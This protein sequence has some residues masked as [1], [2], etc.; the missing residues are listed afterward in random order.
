MLHIKKISSR[1]DTE[2]IADDIDRAIGGSDF[3]KDPDNIS[4]IKSLDVGDEKRDLNMAIAD[5]MHNPFSQTK[6][7]GKI[8]LNLFAND[9]DKINIINLIKESNLG[10]LGFGGNCFNA[11]KA[12]MDFFFEEDKDTYTVG[13]LNKFLFEN[14]IPMGHAAVYDNGTYIDCDG[15]AKNSDMIES[16]A[17]IDEDEMLSIIGENN[18][19]SEL[20]DYDFNDQEFDSKID[21]ICYETILIKDFDQYIELDQEAMNKIRDTLKATEKSFELK[22]VTS[23]DRLD[24]FKKIS[25]LNEKSQKISIASGKKISS[26]LRYH[27]DNNIRLSSNIFRIHSQSYLD[28]FNE[29]RELMK[30]GS[31]NV[32]KEDEW[33]L[34]TDLGKTATING[35]VVPLDLPIEIDD[36]ESYFSKLSSKGKLN[37]PRRVGKGDPGY[38]RKKFIVHVKDPSTGRVKTV[39]FGDPNL[40]IKANNPE[41]RKSFLARHNCDNP[42]PKTGA[43]YWSCNLHRYKKQLGLKFE[44]RW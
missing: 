17:M 5:N 11:A 25:S 42:G 37:S 40:S 19:E 9:Y 15:V 14:G 44:G 12:I 22:K 3:L 32:C 20:E 38:G 18:L 26:N 13:Y 30:S 2:N 31:L 24:R 10:P 36:D 43:R 35:V 23:I 16:W 1:Q 21:Q 33:L 8:R 27:I 41:R 7:D 29:A 6:D 34:N 39:T 4:Y 28:L